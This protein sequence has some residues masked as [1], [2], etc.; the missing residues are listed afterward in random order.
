MVLPQGD[1][2]TADKLNALLIK[3]LVSTGE[4]NEVETCDVDFDHQFLDGS[5]DGIRAACAQGRMIREMALLLCLVGWHL[6]NVI[7]G[8]LNFYE[9]ILLF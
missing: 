1:F 8:I 6:K 5:E 4:L 3:A 2:N 7:V 9:D